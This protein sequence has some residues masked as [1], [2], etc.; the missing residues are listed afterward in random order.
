MHKKQT[1]VCVVLLL[2]M[3]VKYSVAQTPAQLWYQ[4]AGNALGPVMGVAVSPQGRLYASVYHAGIFRSQDTGKT[5]Q[6]VAPYTDGVWTMAIRTNGEIIA[7][8][9][10]RGVFHSTD[11]GGTWSVFA[12]PMLNADV[13]AV[14]AAGAVFIES[15]GTMYR[16]SHLDTSWIALPVNGGAVAVNG[17]NMVAAKGTACYR[18][19]DNGEA[20]SAVAALPAPVY[21]VALEP[22]G[23]LYAGAFYDNM[24]PTSSIFSL[25]AVSGA[26]V[27]SGPPS[28]INAI[29][30]RHDGVLFAAS[31]DSGFFFSTSHGASWKRYNTG[32]SSPKIYSL[33]LLNDTTI[34]AG[35]VDGI[36]FSSGPLASLLPVELISFTATVNASTVL[37]QWKTATEVNNYGF[38]LERRLLS[39]EPGE[40]PRSG[41]WTDIGFTEGGGT[42]NVPREYSF[43]DRVPLS[44]LYEYRLKQIDRDGAVEFLESIII[45]VKLQPKEYLLGQNYPNPFNPSTTITYQLPAA[46]YITLTVSDVT[47]RVVETVVNELQQAGP[48]SVRFDRTGL[49]SGIYLYTLRAGSFSLTRRMVLLR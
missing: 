3:L 22:S 26:W 39:R 20:W 37:L 1:I 40:T 18:S 4:K 41:V 36:F 31:H 12:D 29:I 48:H 16:S 34:I 8:L 23:G 15:A 43:A 32:L 14:N 6:Q 42:S 21:A 25:N 30:R 13:R 33:A 5:W 17:S 27:G 35:T 47:G 10:S 2:G 28:T 9:W 19:T 38:V 44:G 49:A 24:N 46:G 45:A 7:S 11:H